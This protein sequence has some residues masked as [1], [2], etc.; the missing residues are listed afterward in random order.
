MR[1]IGLVRRAAKG[2]ALTSEDHDGNLDAIEGDVGGVLFADMLAPVGG[3]SV[4]NQ[5]A[6]FNAD[7][8][9]AHAPQRRERA[10]DIG[11]YVFI[12]PFHVNHDIKPGGKAYL[13]VH[14]S[15]NGSNTGPVAWEL[16]F[17]RALG[18]D[19][20]NFTAPQVVVLEQ[21]ASGT[22]WRHMIVEAGESDV[23][24]MTEPDE[25]I[26]V[27]LRRIAPSAGSNADTVFGLMVD[28]HYEMD[29][30]GTPGKSPDFY[31]G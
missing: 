3:A 19:Q 27:T 28:L 22:P 4:P 16:T 2:A 30:R 13:H 21:A 5:N 17:M 11:D 24:T 6:P 18:H 23:I 31:A 15:T 8:G 29:R 1:Q 10:F 9:P 12:Q 26:M 7:F 20:D 25:L 14:W